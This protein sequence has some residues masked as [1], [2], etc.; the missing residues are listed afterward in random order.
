MNRWIISLSLALLVSC[1]NSST[2]TG[3]VEQAVSGDCVPGGN[4][5]GAKTPALPLWDGKLPDSEPGQ[6]F[7]DVAD[8]RKNSK[9]SGEGFHV[10][11]LADPGKGE[12]VWGATVPDQD[13]G[14]LRSNPGARPMVGDCC[15]PPPCGCRGCCDDWMAANFLEAGLRYIEVPANAEAAAGPWK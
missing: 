15:R 1:Q 2:E 12:L 4:Y 14:M 3:S 10:V 6:I 8:Y 7:L 13:L 5:V 9:T 11:V